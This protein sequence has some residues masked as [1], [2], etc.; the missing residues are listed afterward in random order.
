MEFN[1]TI[2]LYTGL[3]DRIGDM[4]DVARLNSRIDHSKINVHN[5]YLE[6]FGHFTFYLG[7]SNYHLDYVL[8]DFGYSVDK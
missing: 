4:A 1:K 8:A 7:K 6:G 2:H 3:E 5:R